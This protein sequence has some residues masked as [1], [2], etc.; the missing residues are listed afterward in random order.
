MCANKIVAVSLVL[1]VSSICHAA[2]QQVKQVTCAG[3]VVDV[4]VR[5]IA[6]AK[7]SLNHV[8]Y[9]ESTRAA[10]SKLA[11]ET[12]TTAN[13]G[14]FSFTA[15]LEGDSQEHDFEVLIDKYNSCNKKFQTIYYDLETTEQFG[16]EKRVYSFKYCSNNE[17]KQWIGYRTQYSKDGTVNQGLSGLLRDIY[18]DK[19]GVHLQLYNPERENKRPPNAVLVRSSLD[20]YLQDYTEHPPYGGSIAGRFWGN[21]GQSIYDLLKGA[22]NL[23]LHD[24]VTKIIGHDTCLIEADTQYGIVKAWISPNL[25]YNCLKWEIIKGPN[26]YYRD[27]AFVND[28]FTKC[29][30]VY[31]AEKVKQIDGQ[32]IITPAGL[33]YRVDDGDIVLS[34]LKYHFHLKNIDLNPDYEALKAFEI[35]LPEGTVATHEEVPGIQFRW[36][37]GKFVPNVDD[38]L[39]KNLIGKP[40]PS[41]EGFMIGLEQDYNKEKTLL[42]CLWDMQQRPS[43]NC[44]LQL[45]KRA[46]EL[47]AKKVSIV[48]VQASKVDQ[49]ALDKWLKKFNI[50]FPVGM[51]QTDAEKTRFSWGVKSLP[52]LILTDR[53][54][55]VVTEGFGL[56]ELNTKISEI[57]N[58]K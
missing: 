28:E 23:T 8:V 38:Y 21:N 54:H 9:D 41:L 48:A 33:N 57:E 55:V 40:L 16:S 12:R 49:N 53:E 14:G 45:S 39:Y 22:Q 35:Q 50:P 31:E 20:K 27:G 11:I 18:S 24:K 47:K 17:K 52:W 19:V 4:Q 1:L 42:V 46:Q 7:V 30:A 3:K 43:R 6:G 29:T 34:N 58:A 32:Y 37:N 25:D 56:D 36:T 15:T 2:T 10:D 5:P 44:L 26:Q 13:D 51:V